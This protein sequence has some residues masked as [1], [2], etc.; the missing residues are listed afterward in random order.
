MPSPSMHHC[1]TMR[2][3]SEVPMRMGFRLAQWNPARLRPTEDGF[4]TRKTGVQV[5]L[6]KHGVDQQA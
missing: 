5:R 1:S 4:T 6:V 3:A 2:S